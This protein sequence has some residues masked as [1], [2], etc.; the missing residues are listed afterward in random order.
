[1]SVKSP[2]GLVLYCYF[3][4]PTINKTYLILYLYIDGIIIVLYNVEILPAGGRLLSNNQSINYRCIPTTGGVNSVLKNGICG[5]F[6]YYDFNAV[7]YLCCGTI[8]P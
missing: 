1:M 8:N 5:T 3:N 6:K 4:M 7:T 2:V